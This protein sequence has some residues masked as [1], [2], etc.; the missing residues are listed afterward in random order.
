MRYLGRVGPAV[1]GRLRRAVAMLAAGLTVAAAL[2]VITPVTPAEA[3]SASEFQA[4]NI[5]SDANF[6][7][8]NAMT[9]AQ[10][11]AFL[12]AKIG[13]CLN[14]LCL[15]VYKQTTTSR[16]QD[17]T[18]CNAYA[19]AADEPASR[20]IFKVQQACGI[21]AKVILV[22]LQKEQGLVLKNSPTSGTLGRAMGYACPDNTGGTCDSTYYGFFNQ[23]YRGSWQMKRYSTPDIFGGFW[24]GQ[25]R[26]ILYSPNTGC[27]AKWVTIQNRAT[28]ALY[29]Y[30][31]YTPTAAALAAYPG[32]AS[33][34]DALCGSY[35]NRNFWFLYNQWFG[36]SIDVPCVGNPTKEITDYWAS[37]GGSTGPFGDAVSPGIVAGPEG[38]TI[39][40]YANGDIYCT[41]SVGPV[42]LL[43]DV[44]AKFNAL[45]AVSGALGTPLSA[46]VAFSAGGVSGLLQEFEHGTMLSSEATGT[47]AVLDG[48]MRSAWGSRGGS[49][50]ALGWPTGDQRSSDGGVWQRFQNGVLVVPSGKSAIALLDEVGGYWTT[51]QNSV[52]LGLPTTTSTVWVAGGVS[53]ELQ[54]FERGM[55]LSP[56]STGSFAVVN[57]LM[58][59]AWGSRGGSGG[60]LGWPIGDQQ[61]AK[62]MYWQTF[63]HGTV[64][65]APSG[66]S[67]TVS[68][69]I[70]DYWATGSNPSRLGAAVGASTA[71][72]AGGVSGY[73]QY[74]ERGLVMSSATT[75]TFAVLNGPMRSSWGARGGSGG[76]L[77]WPIGDQQTTTS[78]VRQQF[79]GGTV[80]VETSLTG[81]IAAYWSTSSNS[82]RLGYPTAPAAAWSAGGVSGLLQYFDRGMVLSSASSGTFSVLD[83]PIR[84]AWGAHGGSGGSLGWPTADQVAVAGGVQQ[85][86]QRGV[87][88]VPTGDTIGMVLSGATYAYWSAGANASRL[89][90]PTGSAVAWS[91]GGVTGTLQYFRNGLV[92]S[93]GTTGTFAVL[94]GDIY[95]AWARENGSGGSLGWPTSDREP[96]VG[97]VWQQFQRGV[98]IA[99]TGGMSIVHSGAI[100]AYWSTGSR[101]S[102][103]G[104]PTDSEQ[105]WTAGG[106][107]GSYQVFDRGMVMS[108]ADT[109]TFA[110]VAGPIRNAWGARDGS[111]GPL[112]WPTGDQESVADGVRQAF[113]RGT[114][115]VLSDGTTITVT[116][117][118]Y[119]Y[120][121]T[122]S[123]AKLLG[124]AV[125]SPTSWVAGGVTG[126][127]QVFENGMVMSSSVTGTHAVLNGPIRKTWGEQNGSGGPL[128]WPIADQLAVDGGNKQQFQHGAIMVP[129]TGD[130]YIIWN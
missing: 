128:G 13:A 124:A 15:N 119:L 63:Q 33:G 90:F 21:S 38:T 26:N 20:I 115:T 34:A 105:G 83:G 98:I 10:I 108:S 71:W 97:G 32:P 87:I 100:G 118:Y 41:P 117:E 1:H 113:H 107:T 110:V 25:S 127:Y 11:Q 80:T 27:G 23:V 51:G 52:V 129:T 96:V 104:F 50:G 112:G 29:A 86:F 91:A 82:T 30:T 12:D 84:G 68:G 42:G 14:T 39:G 45:G 19:G 95:G 114:L 93:S 70:G 53:G 62:G 35:G 74:F 54:Y 46:S 122:G 81:D 109:G 126:S 92:L 88:V 47:F 28:A 9:E 24:A 4:G 79:Q 60:P 123:N 125:A 44:R 78:D 7:D 40:F 43:G 75:G 76:A 16:A 94:H 101:A 5:I 36:S 67:E 69:A 89:G 2:V 18:V 61:S 56:A 72:S 73:L 120:W 31:P 116:G 59:S 48:P 49:G 77:G 106:V 65:I 102:L 8:G 85:Q 3:V 64:T 103:L 37:Q 17:R 111:R 130:P 99:P 57:G 121:S 6:Y 66:V 55:V 22:T 58:R